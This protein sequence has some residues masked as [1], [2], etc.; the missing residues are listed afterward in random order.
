MNPQVL[1]HHWLF[2]ARIHAVAPSSAL[3]VSLEENHTGPAHM[4]LRRFQPESNRLSLGKGHNPRGHPAKASHCSAITRT[5]ITSRNRG[6]S[7]STGQRYCCLLWGTIP[8]PYIIS[9]QPSETHRGEKHNQNSPQRR[10]CYVNKKSVK[11]QKAPVQPRLLTCRANQ[12]INI[13]CTSAITSAKSTRPD[14]FLTLDEFPQR[15]RI[16]HPLT[17][18]PT[19]NTQ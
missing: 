10:R 9:G 3:C 16:Q 4:H 6:H 8:H 7:P 11:N 13:H 5:K 1:T 14:P 15:W 12:Q 17:L 19:L 18:Y 2:P